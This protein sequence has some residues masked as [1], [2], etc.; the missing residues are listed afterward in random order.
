MITVVDESDRRKVIPKSLV[1][2]IEG[3]ENVELDLTGKESILQD[4]S[5]LDF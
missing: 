2:R 5:F 1:L 4:R 3:R